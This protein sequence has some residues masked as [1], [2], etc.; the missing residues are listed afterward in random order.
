MFSEQWLFC[1]QTSDY[2]FSFP[3]SS[4]DPVTDKNW[5]QRPNRL[6]VLRDLCP[7]QTN[8]NLKI[9]EVRSCNITGSSAC[10]VFYCSAKSYLSA[11]KYHHAPPP[12]PQCDLFPAA[13]LEA[14]RKLGGWVFLTSCFDDF[15]SHRGT[16][17]LTACNSKK[18]K[19]QSWHSNR[20]ATA[21]ISMT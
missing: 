4:L 16:S 7:G 14:I 12:S 17:Y 2:I 20:R 10:S 6:V 15:R 21:L 11:T 5:E 13:V 1:W 19:N 8:P 18:R 9:T 3:N